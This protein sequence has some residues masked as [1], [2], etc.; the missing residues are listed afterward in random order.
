M[1]QSANGIYNGGDHPWCG[2]RAYIGLD[3]KE[4]FSAALAASMSKQPINFIYDDAAPSVNIA[5]HTESHCRVIS[6]FQ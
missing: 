6:I 4:L 1:I 5:G 3:D 2:R